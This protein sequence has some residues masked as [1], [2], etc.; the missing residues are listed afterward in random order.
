MTTTVNISLPKSMYAEAKQMVSRRGYSS[1][2]ELI[3]EALRGVLYPNLTENDFTPEFEDE[4]LRRA[5]EPI[6]NAIAWDG[7]TPFVK[8]V[9]SHPTKNGK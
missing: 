2:S 3:R 4:V 9:L 7:K 6:T 5:A 1:I 8:F